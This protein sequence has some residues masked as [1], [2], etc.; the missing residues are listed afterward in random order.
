MLNL[1]DK[2]LDRMARQAADEYEPGPS[3]GPGQWNKLQAGLDREL[4]KVRFNPFRAIRRMPFY[5]APAVLLLATVAYYFIRHSSSG[6]P[7][8]S[9]VKA[10]P[11]QPTQTPDESVNTKN[12][13]YKP[14]S[15]PDQQQRTKNP[16][17]RSS[18]VKNPEVPASTAQE[19]D[20]RNLA[21]AGGPVRREE[22]KQGGALRETES[23]VD[24]VQKEAGTMTRK[25]RGKNSV[26][27]GV[28]SGRNS[29]VAGISAGT[30]SG[31]S[32][33]G[34]TATGT[35]NEAGDANNGVAGTNNGVV[36]TNHGAA[37]ANNELAPR[38]HV[39]A[40]KELQHSTIR[41]QASHAG[42]PVVDDAGL[43]GIALTKAGSR[44]GPITPGKPLSPSMRINRSLQIGL[45]VAPDFASVNSLAGDRPGS[46]MG[47]TLDYQFVNKLYLSTGILF[48]RKNY[49]A[50]AQDYHVPYDYYIRN[51]LHNVDFVKGTFNLLEI[52]LN[53]RY[54][55]SVTG[56]TVFF[57]SGGLS[58]YLLT[59]ENCNYYFDLFGREAWR[60]FNYKGGGAHL[61]SA[62]NLSIGVE[63]GLSNDLSLLISPY[64]KV[65][66]GG[67]GFGRIDVNSMGINFGVKYAP[68]LRRSRH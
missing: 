29:V 22:V 33:H 8:P 55:F 17:Y 50:T 24:P 10:M 14:T 21:R 7:P 67:L 19:R 45:E 34:A 6:S 63:T 66:T 64:V 4:G 49:T 13:S 56:N 39:V 32:H 53:F 48:S 15:T 30:R 42:R 68:V 5:F 37:D 62:V 31:R 35:H 59:G 9:V 44:P 40:G 36:D 38:G 57:A 1:S 16:G 12:L 46:S 47:L 11:R 20:S 60:G 3:K 28:G 18:N 52:P 41:E 61:F 54:D 58:S 65:P 23:S 2:E 25:S 43:R 51:N 26:A 27:A